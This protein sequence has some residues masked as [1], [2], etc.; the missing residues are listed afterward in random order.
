MGDLVPGKKRK[1]RSVELSP[2]AR[3]LLRARLLVI[4]EQS[5]RQRPK[6]RL[7]REVAAEF[8]GV[9]IR[10]ADRILK[11]EAVDPSSLEIAFQSVG[12]DWNPDYIASAEWQSKRAIPE[13]AIEPRAEAAPESSPVPAP[14]LEAPLASERT[15]PRTWWNRAL[16]A[17]VA[18]ALAVVV[19]GAVARVEVQGPKPVEW[20]QQYD[21]MTERASTCYRIADYDGAWSAASLA[22]EIAVKNHNAVALANSLRLQGDI[23]CAQGDPAKGL[24][25]YRQSLYFQRAIDLREELY[26]TLEVAGDACVSLK[27]FAEAKRDYQECVAHAKSTGNLHA[28]ATALRGLGRVACEQGDHEEAIAKFEEAMN[29]VGTKLQP[30]TA[31][32]LK[33]LRAVAMGMSGQSDEAIEE[34]MTCLEHWKAR[35]HERWI[36]TTHFQLAQVYVARGYLTEAERCWLLAEDGYS[37]VG[38][39]AGKKRCEEHLGRLGC[40]GAKM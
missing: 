28:L 9:S 15:R 8:M 14:A 37:R 21:L 32:D 20:Q 7:T 25:L 33:G 34:L 12:L 4:I 6:I 10:T 29:L 24:G 19:L 35:R 3:D 17:T 31:A 5:R 16:N 38:D 22:Q 13:P 26:S 40:A 23:L 30:D 39:Q 18:A 27:H 2:A 36:A 1:K 11:L